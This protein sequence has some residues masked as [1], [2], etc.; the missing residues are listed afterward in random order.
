MP[1][2]TFSFS[3]PVPL[4]FRFLSNQRKYASAPSRI[5]ASPPRTPATIPML[6]DFFCTAAVFIPDELEAEGGFVA[7]GECAVNVVVDELEG[8]CVGGV[9]FSDRAA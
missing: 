9:E 4:F 7:E 1:T 2:T 5:A 3:I 8:E 6:F